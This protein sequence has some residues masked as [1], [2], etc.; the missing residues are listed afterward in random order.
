[1]KLRRIK[2]GDL[3]KLFEWR[4]KPEVYRWCRQFAPLHWE[5]HLA[6]YAKQVADP[7]IEMFVIEA[8]DDKMVG[9]CGLTDIDLVNRRA[10][11][12]LYIGPEFWHRGYAFGGLTQLFSWGF[13]S[14][15][16][17]RIFGE[18]FRDNPAAKIF[19][20]LGMENEG[21]R[22]DHYFRNSNFI[23]AYLYSISAADF[24]RLY[25]GFKS[26]G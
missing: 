9:L 16:L 7:K 6:W 2:E 4:N 14:L 18:T 19:E 3:A 8:D 5:S 23:D 17:N 21:I 20:R 15:G 13:N 26:L 10:E 24:N 1:M 25:P 22:R 11:F 12:S